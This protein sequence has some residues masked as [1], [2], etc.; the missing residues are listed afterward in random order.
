VKK[1][2]LFFI[3]SSLIFSAEFT[4][5][6]IAQIQSALTSSESN[7]QDDKITI[8]SG[9][10]ILSSEFVFTSTE[11]F[12]LEIVGNE[13]VIFNG[14]DSTRIFNIN[15]TGG[16]VI[17]DNL[18]FE[19]GFC[20]GSSVSAGGAIFGNNNNR[21]VVLNSF[22]TG[23]KGTS[24]TN[25]WGGAIFTYQYSSLLVI[26]SKFTGN[27][28]NY[29]GSMFVYNDSNLTVINSSFAGETAF[30]TGGAIRTHNV[31]VLVL[32]SVFYNN[33]ASIGFDLG[34]SS[35]TSANVY[36]SAIAPTSI[37]YAETNVV[38]NI[39]SGLSWADNVNLVI[40]NSSSTIG[41]GLP[42]A[43][44]QNSPAIESYVSPEIY[45]IL[46]D[47]YGDSPESF[48]NMGASLTI[49]SYIPIPDLGAIIS[50]SLDLTFYDKI[51]VEFNMTNEDTIMNFSNDISSDEV[52]VK[53]S[54]TTE[55]AYLNFDF[56]ESNSVFLSVRDQ[57][58]INI[59]KS[60]SLN[61][62][63]LHLND[64]GLDDSN[65][66]ADFNLTKTLGSTQFG[67]LVVAND[68]W[69][70]ITIPHGLHTNSREII[71]QEKATMIW[72]WEFDGS[73]YDWVAY[74]KKMV[75]GRGYWVRTRISANTE[76]TLSNVIA[77]DYNSTVL[78]DYNSSEIN[79]SNLIEVV[80][81]LPK[82]ENWV[83]L[84]NSGSPA[85][86]I[87]K[88]G[89]ENNST[90]YYFGDLLNNREECYFVSIY[91]WKPEIENWAND[92]SDGN[93]SEPIPFG[94]GFWTKQR[95]CNK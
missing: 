21:I 92:T 94:A 86:I 82:K 55:K 70:L 36:N 56:N 38:D 19:N 95:L 68:T 78:G 13:D 50:A 43:V 63:Q 65:I 8:N 37:D 71:K 33:T 16:K 57:N 6:T 60:N 90:K 7:G 26:N 72:G 91:H 54:E 66:S 30:A 75:S 88:I 89:T 34:L 39:T 83:L 12:N 29:G 14:N 32:N 77:T 27:E 59:I 35:P 80:S 41:S 79:T 11:N 62:L 85:Q 25:A 31:N 47:N 74:P 45:Q 67:D 81:L 51:R 28:A 5:S 76:G 46:N 44:V 87:E 17:F 84:G 1:I 40:S 61:S 48:L 9:T 53:N 93:T 73:S 22:F 49:S 20:A 24:S 58:G 4:V 15:S 2:V 42:L 64:S 10:Y 23:N 18:R 52:F 3:F 69:N